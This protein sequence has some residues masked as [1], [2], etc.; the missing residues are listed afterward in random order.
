MVGPQAPFIPQPLTHTNSAPWWYDAFADDTPRWCES[1]LNNVRRGL[2]H[3]QYHL[4]ETQAQHA[5]LFGS[6]PAEV[7][8]AAAAVGAAVGDAH[9]HLTAIDKAAH[10]YQGAERQCAM[11]CGEGMHVKALAAGGAPVVK[12]RAVPGGMAALEF[13]RQLAI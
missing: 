7:D 3:K 13:A 11:G 12:T 1:R 6:A 2:W 9:I 8:D 4:F 10:P 5:E